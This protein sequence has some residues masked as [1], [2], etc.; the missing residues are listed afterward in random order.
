VKKH[1]ASTGCS[2]TVDPTAFL[3]KPDL[4]TATALDRDYNFLQKIGRDI[5]LDKSDARQARVTKPRDQWRAGARVH[6]VGLGMSRRKRNRSKWNNAESQF[7]WTIEVIGTPSSQYVQLGDKTSVAA[8]PTMFGRPATDRVLLRTAFGQRIELD[9]EKTFQDAI[10]GKDVL[11]FPSIEF[12]TKSD[13]DSDSSSSDSDSDSDST[14]DS[15]SDSD[16]DSGSGSD[17]DSEPNP[18][19]VNS[20]ESEPSEPA[21]GEPAAAEPIKSSEPTD[22]SKPVKP[23]IEQPSEPNSGGLLLE[24]RSGSESEPPE[25]LPT[26]TS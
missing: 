22:L 17:S 24:T 10:R 21:A 4:L 16:S 7:E 19:L 11:E 9:K 25:E 2:G 8:L 18:T 14:S 12:V 1:K 20:G 6:S 26:R 13:S 15:D 3:A 23:E 5:H